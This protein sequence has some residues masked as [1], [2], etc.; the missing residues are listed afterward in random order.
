MFCVLCMRTCLSA[1]RLLLAALRWALLVW[2][3]GAGD[4]IFLCVLSPAAR[5]LIMDALSRTV[6][7]F[8]AE[9]GIWWRY[10][11]TDAEL[12]SFDDGEFFT[13]RVGIVGDSLEVRM[14]LWCCRVL[15]RWVRLIVLCCKVITVWLCMG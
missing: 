10:Y 2:R 14:R 15:P 11:L 7:G 3:E 4:G 9:S 6:G 8:C 1:G 12:A 5:T 13:T